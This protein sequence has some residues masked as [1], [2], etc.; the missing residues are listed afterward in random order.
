MHLIDAIDRRLK[1]WVGSVIEESSVSFHAPGV[2]QARA[3]VGLYLLEL[4]E[5]KPPSG[6][7]RAPLQF[8]VRYLVTAPAAEPERAHEVLGRLVFA[9]MEEPEFS[10]GFEAIPPALWSAFGVPPQPAFFLDIPV[11]KE[12]AEPVTGLVRQPLIVHT[13]PLASF[14][15]V[16]V[17]PGEIP[18]PNARVEIP[19]LRLVTTTDRKGAFHFTTLP[20]G[21]SVNLLIHARGKKFALTAAQD[22]VGSDRPFV[23]QF[24]VL[25]E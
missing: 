19:S 20:S 25:E 8:S 24:P 23:I 3:S 10:V 18:L 4:R 17:G 5:N 2:D 6:A 9:A 21:R 15:G 16:V 22:C 7:R 1:D 11:R 13:S 14:Q 12:R